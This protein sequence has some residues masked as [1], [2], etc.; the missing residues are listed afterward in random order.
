MTLIAAVLSVTA[1]VASPL[2]LQNAGAPA[3]RA[4]PFVAAWLVAIE[5]AVGDRRLIALAAAAVLLGIAADVHDAAIVASPA[6]LVIGALTA[7]RGRSQSDALKMLLVSAATFAA[8]IVPQLVELATHPEMI[9]ARAMA[10]GLYDATRFS[11]LQGMREIISW[12]SLTSR[13]ESYWSYLDPSFVCFSGRVLYPAALPL[14]AIAMWSTRDQPRPA[15]V[16]ASI[17]GLFAVP[18][19]GALAGQ[20]VVASRLILMLPCAAALQA[21]GV[22]QAWSIVRRW[23]IGPVGPANTRTLPGGTSSGRVASA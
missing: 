23:T 17:G 11:P 21:Y 13:A 15:F 2:F 4:V 19:A 6:L 16:V 18:L 8:A 7:V 20:P 22:I 12:V 1:M 5:Y 14:I 9:A 10:H 3:M